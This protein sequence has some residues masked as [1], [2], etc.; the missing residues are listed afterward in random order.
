MIANTIAGILK[1]G[2]DDL[3]TTTPNGGGQQ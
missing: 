1:I 2:S 3:V